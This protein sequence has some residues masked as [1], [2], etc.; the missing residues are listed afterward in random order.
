MIRPAI[1]A[2]C[3]T[4]IFALQASAQKTD[5]EPLRFAAGAVLTFHMQTRMNPGDGNE[6]DLL[7]QG[8]ALRVRIL[9]PIDSTADQDGSEFR[10]EI[11]SAVISGGE[12]IVHSQ[13]KVRGILA[14]LRSRNHPEGF[15]Y[16]L[17]ITS[18]EDQ[19]KTYVLT[20]SLMP[21][22]SDTRPATASKAPEPVSGTPR[23]GATFGAEN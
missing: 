2:L 11:A 15:R 9:Q 18:V 20:A 5:I 8:T 6:T 16:E 7:P 23:T 12:T 4:A 10:G 17:L 3:L 1:G 22:I 19:G 21:T 13:A 14:L